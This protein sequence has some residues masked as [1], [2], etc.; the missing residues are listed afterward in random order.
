MRCISYLTLWHCGTDVC[1]RTGNGQL[2]T[3]ILTPLGIHSSIKFSCFQVHRI[4]MK[5]S[6]PPSDGLEKGEGRGDGSGE[7]S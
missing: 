7:T 2:K 1:Q 6:W 3:K 5:R 4:E